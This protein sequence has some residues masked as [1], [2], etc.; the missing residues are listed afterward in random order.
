MTSSSKDRDAVA[1]SLQP[2]AATTSFNDY[3]NDDQALPHEPRATFSS[4][5]DAS[6]AFLQ[7]FKKVQQDKRIDRMRRARNLRES[8]KS[9]GNETVSSGDNEAAAPKSFFK[10]ISDRTPLLVSNN[11]TFK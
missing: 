1:L 9:L 11:M 10:I 8:M 6:M 7:I 4:T 3:I 5:A 2:D